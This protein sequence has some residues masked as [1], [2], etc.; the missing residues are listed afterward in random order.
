MT[1]GHSH[2][3]TVIPGKS[4]LLNIEAL[5]ELGHNITN[6][7]VFTVSIHRDNKSS[8]SV[9][10]RAM[11][12]VSDGCF[13]VGGP[14][15]SQASLSL[16]SM[17]VSLKLNVTI[18]PCL[19]RFVY[20]ATQKRCKC[21]GGF[22]GLLH[23]EPQDFTSFISL[24]GCIS[25]ND[26]DGF[27][28]A[29]HCPF[30]AGSQKMMTIRLNESHSFCKYI[31]RLGR[32]CSKCKVGYGIAVFSSN[33]KCVPCKESYKNWLKYFAIEFVPLTILFLIVLIFHVGITSAA[34]NAFIFFSQLVSL[35]LEVPFITTAWTLWLK[36]PDKANALTSIVIFH[37]T[38]GALTLL[39]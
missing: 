10:M 22:G 20:N 9:D 33:F 18:L 6:Q 11:F 34:T 15:D 3:K 27:P 36:E 29:T 2:N 31:Y 16:D 38:F 7:T 13:N 25:F 8:Q 37:T 30:S 26:S 14:P 35:P 5:D 39:L 1:I 12:Y 21:G 4:E 17:A 32:L 23:C 28:V 24:G 19:P